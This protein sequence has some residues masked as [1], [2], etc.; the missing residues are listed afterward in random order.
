MGC[1][2][3]EQMYQNNRRP[4]PAMCAFSAMRDVG[5]YRQVRPFVQ[6]TGGCSHKER[7]YRNNGR[8]SPHVGAFSAM[9]DVG[10]YRQVRPL[11]Q[12]TGGYVHKERMYQNNRRLITT[13]TYLE[14][15]AR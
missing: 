9:C 14:T 4:I 6:P 15:P 13:C 7:M 12:P 2:H 1:I 10:T 8:P 3:N 11:V 5:T